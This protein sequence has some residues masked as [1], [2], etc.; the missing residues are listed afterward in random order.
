MYSMKTTIDCLKLYG[1]INF[2]LKV[3]SQKKNTDS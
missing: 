1:P 2:G 3:D